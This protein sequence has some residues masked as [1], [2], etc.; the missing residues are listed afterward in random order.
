VEASVTL[1]TTDI[2]LIA[3]HHEDCEHN[4]SHVE[5]VPPVVIRYIAVISLDRN[6]EAIQLLQHGDTDLNLTAQTKQH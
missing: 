3:T 5:G 2:L 1:A 6:Q 4:L